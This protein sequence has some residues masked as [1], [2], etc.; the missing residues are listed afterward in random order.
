MPLDV[1]GL[2]DQNPLNTGFGQ[3]L[4]HNTSRRDVLAVVDGAINKAGGV[5]D[6]PLG[7]SVIHNDQASG[8]VRAIKKK[9]N[10]GRVRE[11]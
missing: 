10:Q 4:Q 2:L 1:Q 3:S 6:V 7:Y 8:K 5:G 11:I 9:V